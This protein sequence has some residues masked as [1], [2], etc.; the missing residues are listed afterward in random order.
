M[1]LLK[2]VSRAQSKD[3]FPM[4]YTRELNTLLTEK[5]H[6][7][8]HSQNTMDCSSFLQLILFKGKT[9]A[10]NSIAQGWLFFL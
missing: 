7:L 5:V 10:T 1:L 4:S 6:P 2:C 8:S 3:N 9:E